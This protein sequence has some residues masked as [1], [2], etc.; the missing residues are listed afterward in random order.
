V[1][2][3]TWSDSM[4][5]NT[6]EIIS[7]AD[8]FLFDPNLKIGG[9]IVPIFGFPGSGKTN[10]LV[11]IAIENYK[12]DYIVLWKGSKEA[13]WLNLVANDMPVTL[14]NHENIT[15]FKPIIRSAYPG[16]EPEV[17]NLEN[18]TIDKTLKGKKD[19]QAVR[20][21][22]W[23][24]PEWL[25]DNPDTDRANVI[26]I[27]GSN[28]KFDSKKPRY[29]YLKTWRNIMYHL[30]TRSYG[31]PIMFL[32]DEWNEVMPSQSELRK[33][34]FNVVATMMPKD[35][36]Q[37]RK[38]KVFLYGAAHGTHDCHHMFW[39]V[40]ANSI[41]YMRRANVKKDISPLVD[42]QK[43]NNF[44]R[45]DFV[46][47][48]FEKSRFEMAYEKEDLDWIPDNR[49][50]DFRLLWRIDE[51]IVEDDEDDEEED[52]SDYQHKCSEC[53]YEWEGR[54]ENPVKC[55]RCQKRSWNE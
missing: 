7:D 11:N 15:D 53:G 21:R 28:S 4:D 24:D 50:R 27:P 19:V 29:F 32:G 25:V 45:G 55:P 34:F 20:I 12:E 5:G 41:I 42:Q 13:Q 43:V 6:R 17:V 33:P 1:E 54:K 35:L 22:E 44:N 40:K 16:Q 9:A 48:G 26:N 49:N 38:N 52:L 3:Q 2:S 8:E 37:L 23:S 46:M 14:W 10:G 39:K 36:A 31:T 18:K 30:R 51:S 47:P